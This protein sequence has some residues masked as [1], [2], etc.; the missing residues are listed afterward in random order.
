MALEGKFDGNG[1]TF[2]LDCAPNLEDE[3]RMETAELETA[4]LETI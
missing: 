3:S 1:E 4:E 2:D